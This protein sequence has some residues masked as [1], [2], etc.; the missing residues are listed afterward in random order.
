[1]P[2][3]PIVTT[4]I[5][6]YF[7]VVRGLLILYVTAIQPIR[8]TSNANA[9]IPFPLN[10]ECIKSLEMALLMPTSANYFYEYLEN[11]CEDKDAL[12]YFGLYADIRTYIRYVEED[13]GEA[14]LRKHADTIYKDYLLP[15]R[16]WNIY[17]PD[18]IMLEL[19]QGYSSNSKILFPLDESLF[20]ELY[21]FSLDVLDAYYKK[22]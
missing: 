17:I 2:H 19:V 14:L 6:Q 11:Q 8:S 7:S 4:E 20:T 9:I 18:N 15:N 16:Q 21:I 12:L 13:E 10:E 22:F 1:M 3:A 5:V